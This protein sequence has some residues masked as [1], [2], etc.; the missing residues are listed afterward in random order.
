[1]HVARA[2]LRIKP[3]TSSYL[4]SWNMRPWTDGLSND[5]LEAST[6]WEGRNTPPPH[7]PVGHREAQVLVGPPLQPWQVNG[8]LQSVDLAHD[9]HWHQLG[10]VLNAHAYKP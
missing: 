6:L 5:E 8:I 3:N 2:G 7:H 4:C 1:M 10:I 9:H